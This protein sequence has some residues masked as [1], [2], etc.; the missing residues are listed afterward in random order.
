MPG[1]GGFPKDSK[2]GALRRHPS[3]HAVNDDKMTAT[4]WHRKLMQACAVAIERADTNGDRNLTFDEFKL[5]IPAR[6]RAA[7]HEATLRELFD[8]VDTNGNGFIT[9]DEFFF[10]GFNFAESF[11][12][13]GPH[14]ILELCKRCDTSRD[15]TLNLR[16]FSKMVEDLGYGSLGLELF[17]DLDSDASGTINCTRP[18]CIPDQIACQTLHCC[19]LRLDG[20]N[21]RFTADLE[22]IQRIKACQSE[23]SRQCKALMTSLSFDILHGTEENGGNLAY[24]DHREHPM[25]TS[26]FTAVT[27]NEIR[28][29]IKQRIIARAARPLDMW[30]TMLAEGEMNK[31]HILHQT[32]DR[33]K[34]P[35]FKLAMK[36]IGFKSMD[37][38][39]M[40]YNVL[41]EVFD[42]LE[43]MSEVFED[44]VGFEV[45]ASSLRTRVEP[46]PPN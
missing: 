38:A 44:S 34:R 23:Y 6:T 41:D 39:Q 18:R 22:M 31:R 43:D 42:E 19:A 10:W 21:S 29:T 30:C 12:G 16:E 24:L 9:P 33:L 36:K 17:F 40:Q 14:G 26:P 15:G 37:D 8:T 35:Q 7:H 20:F 46:I 3:L 11:A 13:I 1:P 25:D 28:E 5:F 4:V 45:R 2:R 27:L 32:A